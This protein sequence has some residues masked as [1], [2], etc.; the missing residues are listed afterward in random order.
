ML[1]AHPQSA[2]HGLT[3][4]KGTSAIWSSPTY[5]A[6]HFQQFNRRIHR[7][8]QNLKT[9]TILITARDTWEESVYEKLNTKTDLTP[10]N[11]PDW[12]GVRISVDTITQAK[13]VLSDLNKKYKFVKKNTKLLDVGAYPGGWAQVASKIIT[14]GKILSLDTKKMDKLENVAFLQCDF[15]EENTKEK[16]FNFK[17]IAEPIFK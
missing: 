12:L 11:V 9:E 3:L 15:L 14:T 8:G 13:L 7:A 2:G 6:E 5:N 4:T 1:F 16:I 17:D 10:M